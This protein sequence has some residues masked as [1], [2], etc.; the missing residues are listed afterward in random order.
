MDCVW[1]LM[2]VNDITSSKWNG[3]PN[4]WFE[5]C[6]STVGEIHKPVLKHLQNVV[7]L[8]VH[9][10]AQHPCKFSMT[11]ILLSHVHFSGACQ[12]QTNVCQVTCQHKS[13]KLN[14]EL[15][16]NMTR[17]R[18]KIHMRSRQRTDKIHRNLIIWMVNEVY[19]IMINQRIKEK[20]LCIKLTSIKSL[21]HFYYPD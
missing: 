18:N 1:K 19:S 5:Y 3:I 20:K 9:P 15:R 17:D 7:V 14:W 10:S 21:M 16:C 4:E 6:L 2:D 8:F 11:K 13:L 12:F